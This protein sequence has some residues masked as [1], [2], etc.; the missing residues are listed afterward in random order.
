M[1]VM[2][3]RGCRLCNSFILSTL[4]KLTFLFTLVSA[5]ESVDV[6]EGI[7]VYKDAGIALAICFSI[8]AAF[9][10][11]VHVLYAYGT[12][13]RVAVSHTHENK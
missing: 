12:K 11:I 5:Q 3:I 2:K 6:R 9:L 8:L 1:D 10:L 7:N 13:K 4:V